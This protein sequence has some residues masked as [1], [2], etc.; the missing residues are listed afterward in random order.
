MNCTDLGHAAEHKLCNPD[1]SGGDGPGLVDTACHSPKIYL[2]IWVLPEVR[3]GPRVGF[4]TM[5]GFRGPPH[6]RC[7][8]V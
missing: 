5:V 4:H 6:L 2:L 1:M 8:L 7:V 3:R